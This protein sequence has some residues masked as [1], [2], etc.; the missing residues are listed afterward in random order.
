MRDPRRVPEQGLQ[1]IA[2]AVQEVASAIIGA[3]GRWIRDRPGGGGGAASGEPYGGAAGG[4]HH[5]AVARAE[6]LIVD[7]DAHHR[8][9]AKAG[10]PHL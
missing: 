6:H 4:D 10:G 2:L 8:V 5:H 7:V 1:G 3:A 9:G